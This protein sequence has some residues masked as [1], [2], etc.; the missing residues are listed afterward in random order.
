MLKFLS[1]RPELLRAASTEQEGKRGDKGL[2]PRG[3]SK[4]DTHPAA[5]GG[6]ERATPAG[7][8]GDGDVAAAT[9]AVKRQSCALPAP[10]A[11]THRP[12]PA[13]FSPSSHSLPLPEPRG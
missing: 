11:S 8:R 13:A 2:N 6:R 9:G 5:H 7:A 1:P 10:L 3:E 4:R 12:L